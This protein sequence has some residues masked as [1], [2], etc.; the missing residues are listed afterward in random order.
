MKGEDVEGPHDN[1]VIY[2]ISAICI[3]MLTHTRTNTSKNMQP[4]NGSVADIISEINVDLGQD[5][6]HSLSVHLI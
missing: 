3:S 5:N 2:D 4:I 1:I 6:I